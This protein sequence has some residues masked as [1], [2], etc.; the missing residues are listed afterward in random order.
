[1]FR[2][3]KCVSLLFACAILSVNASTIKTEKQF[4]QTVYN[5]RR[6][7]FVNNDTGWAVGKIHW[8]QGSKT[9][10]ST[11]LKT[12][13]GGTHWTEQNAGCGKSLYGIT[14]IDAL[15]GWACGDSGTILVTQ[16]GGESWQK[17]GSTTGQVL[18]C[19]SFADR[20]HGWAS[21]DS[22]FYHYFLGEPVSVDYKG[23]ILST[24]D[25][26]DHWTRQQLP[27]SVNRINA[28][29]CVDSLDVWAMGSKMINTDGT[30]EAAL[31]HSLDGGKTWKLQ[32]TDNYV[33]G[34]DLSFTNI[35]FINKQKGCLVGRAKMFMSN[36]SGKTWQKCE[37]GNGYYFQDVQFAD[38]SRL[39]A[40]AEGGVFRSM[41]GG[42]SWTKMNINLFDENDNALS[43]FTVSVTG[44]RVLILGNKSSQCRSLSPWEQPDNTTFAPSF[45]SPSY[46]LERV[47]FSDDK[48]G[49]VV[50]KYGSGPGF[51]GQV[52]LHTNDGGKS[53]NRQ[54]AKAIHTDIPAYRL[55]D[56]RFADSLN[57]WAVG[58]SMSTSGCFLRTIDGGRSWSEKDTFSEVSR[59]SFPSPSNI[60]ALTHSRTEG[61]IDMAHSL[62]AG[63]TWQIVNTKT[64]GS[65]GIGFLDVN[66]DVFFVDSLHGWACGGLGTIIHTS[67]GGA[68]WVNQNVPS[69][70]TSAHAVCVA[71]VDSLTGWLGGEYDTSTGDLAGTVLFTSDGGAHW[72]PRTLGIPTYGDINH[73]QFLDSLH[74]WMCGDGGMIIHTADGGKTWQHQNQPSTYSV[75]RS[76]HLLSDT[77]GW[78]CGS[79]GTILRITQTDQQTNTKSYKPVLDK[80]KQINSYFQITSSKPLILNLVM[81][82]SEHVSISIYS[83]S[84]KRIE[85]I[86]NTIFTSGTHRIKLNCSKYPVG[87]YFI[88]VKGMTFSTT[89]K[90]KTGV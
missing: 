28:V 57:G 12:V 48:H 18:T 10:V 14:F 60:W 25:G 22:I 15:H 84:G 42:T 4:E 64:S 86:A 7:S 62:D 83:L 66:G 73:I 24:S 50:G 88:N 89:L 68:T 2:F 17:K 52:I 76:I 87:I 8:D 36:D 11:I 71:F 30:A 9:Y 37:P 41:D 44:K 80:C 65:L 72:V 20:S 61:Y 51:S 49:W 74:G 38:T 31:Y 59:F 29:K 90:L 16:D 6:M 75:I 40:V 85:Q 35:A 3:L 43:L 1:M 58:S 77:L 46:S 45:I 39:Y 5:L 55:N 33:S 27:D 47:F 19:V 69:S 54:Y 23:F 82:K 26:G 34:I 53:W 21:G 13:D 70:Y 79:E 81:I 78:A 56:V 63:Q 67:D 32:F